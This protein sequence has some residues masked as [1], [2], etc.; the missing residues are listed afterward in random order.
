[1]KKRFGRMGGIALLVVA[2][3]HHTAQ[4]G[5]GS[6]RSSSPDA[7]VIESLRA[8]LAVDVYMPQCGITHFLFWLSWW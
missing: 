3:A 7:L 6:R 8:A 4:A 2:G 5:L 1:M